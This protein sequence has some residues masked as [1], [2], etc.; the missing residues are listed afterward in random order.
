MTILRDIRA[1]E[2][3]QQSH[4]NVQKSIEQVNAEAAEK[5]EAE[6]Q[7]LNAERGGKVV[8]DLSKDIDPYGLHGISLV[9][10]LR[11]MGWPE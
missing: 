5:I 10:R 11:A 6:R 4:R 3:A 9:D 8:L 1:A 2:L 7:K